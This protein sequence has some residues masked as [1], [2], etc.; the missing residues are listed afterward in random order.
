MKPHPVLILVFS[1]A[2]YAIN[3]LA[4]IW[5]LNALFNTGIPYSFKTW[6]AGVILF[7]VIRYTFRVGRS[8]EHNYQHD[9]DEEED[10]DDED[11]QEEEDFEDPR[12]RK[13]RLQK[14]E[15]ELLRY[16]EVRKKKGR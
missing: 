2:L 9:F 3:S 7:L 4:F 8:D 16:Q 5:S 14:L 12:A 6:L 13:E 1:L 15:Q 10:D 11:E